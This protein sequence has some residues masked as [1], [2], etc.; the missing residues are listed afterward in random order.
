MNNPTK[1]S[2]KPLRATHYLTFRSARV[3]NSAGLQYT[4]IRIAPAS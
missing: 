3:T 1:V 4:Q 2:N